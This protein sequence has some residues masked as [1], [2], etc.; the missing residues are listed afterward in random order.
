MTAPVV[1]IVPARAF[2]TAKQRLAPVLSA[3]ERAALARAMLTHV[4]TTL[5]LSPGVGPVFVATDAP[6]VAELATTLGASV[7]LDPPDATLG[8]VVRSGLVRLAADVPRLVCMA[9]LWSLGREEVESL[10]A[11][12][13]SG[14]VTMAPDHHDAGTNALGLP[15][16]VTLPTSFG[17]PDSLRRHLH[18]AAAAQRPVT[19]IDSPGTA[20]DLD[21]PSDWRRWVAREA[22]RAAAG[23]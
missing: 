7:L 11:P 3:P 5:H 15:A 20:R 17:A 16:G 21:T 12:L 8:D 9:D 18:A 22:P 2:R 6:E 19:R 14:I 23:S 1:A 13:A 10:V 4:V